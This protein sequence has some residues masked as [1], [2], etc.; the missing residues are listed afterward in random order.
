MKL[1][2]IFGTGSGKTGNAVFAT[3]AGKQ[4]VR[5]Y[6][7]KVSN[8]NTDAQI[9]QRAK[10]KLLSQ[11][12]AAMAPVI[13]IP[14]KELV[15]AR[16][17]FVKIN[18]PLTSFSE[19][20]ATIFM[21]DIQLTDSQKSLPKIMATIAEGTTNVKVQMATNVNF[22]YDRVRWCIFKK[23]ENFKLQLV[24]TAIEET[25]NAGDPAA[26]H[27]FLNVG[28]GHFVIYAYG[29]SVKSGSARA[30]YES[31]MTEPG[32]DKAVL[33]TMLSISTNNYDFSETKGLEEN[34]TA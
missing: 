5:T 17:R 8:P 7:P 25:G 1:N 4:I 29:M 30:T 13:A 6:Q 32:E 34:V 27:T 9:A 14:K 15:S 31:Y 24:E 16:N 19:G 21:E 11:L 26:V 2:G 12:A 20:N 22:Q 28:E 18:T 10:F 33:E 23:T 3:S